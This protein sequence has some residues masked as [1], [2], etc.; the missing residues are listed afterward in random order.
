MG[1]DQKL[2]WAITANGQTCKAIGFLDPLWQVDDGVR[3]MN[4]GGAGLA[5]PP[6]NEHPTIT[7][8]SRDLAGRVGTPLKLTASATDDGIPKPRTGRGAAG[9]VQIS[10]ILYRGPGSVRF[11]PRR[12]ERVYGKAVEGTTEATFSVPGDYW[13]RAVADDGLL[14][15]FVDLKVTVSN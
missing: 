11:N 3:M 13:L 1:P 7:F 6:S 10:W 15:A 12:S 9:G 8:G 4:H 5:P 14:D 2:T